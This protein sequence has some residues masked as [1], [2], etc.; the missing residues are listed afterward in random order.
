M[1]PSTG[2]LPTNT[3]LIAKSKNF[4]YVKLEFAYILY[5]VE[6]FTSLQ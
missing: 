2:K 4:R 5:M 3:L 1:T 6:V